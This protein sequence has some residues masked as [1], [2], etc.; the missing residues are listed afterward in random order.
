MHGSVSIFLYGIHKVRC[1][2]WP[3]LINF[4]TL[5]DLDDVVI[6]E[7]QFRLESVPWFL[8]DEG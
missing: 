1:G 4:Y 3:I 7:C 5:G 8:S 2:P 6:T